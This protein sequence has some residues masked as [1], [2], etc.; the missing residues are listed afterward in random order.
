[1]LGSSGQSRELSS[2]LHLQRTIGNQG[3]LGFLQAEPTHFEDSDR[4]ANTTRF[5]QDFSQIPVHAKAPLAVP[6]GGSAATSNIH[7]TR[8]LK[9]GVGD[10]EISLDRI[11][12][13]FIRP[14]P[15]AKWRVPP[16]ADL[17]AMLTVGTV[18]EAVV[19]SR[20]RRLLD[21]MNREGRLSSSTCFGDIKVV[22]D[23]IFPA[24]G[25]LDQAAYD[26]YIDLADRTMVYNSVRK[27]MTTPH[28]ADRA[29]L[30]RAMLKV[31]TTAQ[32]VATDEAGLRDVFGPAEWTTARVNYGLI[33]DRL[34]AVSADIQHRIT[35]DYN[36]DAQE[37]FLGG[38][39]SFGGQHMHLLSE[40]VADP[41][42]TGS[43]AT[44]LHEAAHLALSSIDDYV[45]YG[46]VG[47]EAM[48]H[49]KKIVNAAHY[50]E[51]PRRAWSVSRYS[52]QTFTPGVSRSGAPPTTEER[53]KAEGAGYYRRAWDA[54]LDFDDLIKQARRNQLDGTALDKKTVALLLKVSPLMDLTL[55]EQRKSPPDI[56]RLDVTTSESIGRAM[57]LAGDDLRSLTD[58]APMGPFLST[59]DEIAMGVDLAVDA[60]MVAYGGLLGDATRDRKLTDWLHSHY[61][62]VFP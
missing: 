24:P 7:T 48:D 62:N 34:K 56:T 43:M 58:I 30:K 29:D 12:G 41:L 16:S 31:A 36:L 8:G 6:N 52:G 35:T 54:A 28:A 9:S 45:Y 4:T 32:S 33:R 15:D 55:H 61:K 17:Q 40:V 38:W 2:I 5:G 39:A 51:L 25:V 47:F 60:A 19:H 53:I 11:F 23:Q 59:D 27:R 42:T 14:L 57:G 10:N 22:M 20:V 21:R 3:V 49:A 1:M 37:T 46:T 18:D 44:L 26:R 13:E 50:E